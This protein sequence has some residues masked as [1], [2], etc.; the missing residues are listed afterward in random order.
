MKFRLS[1]L[2][3]H[4]LH[5]KT[6][7][8][9]KSTP[10]KDEGFIDRAIQL[11]PPPLPEPTSRTSLLCNI[12]FLIFISYSCIKRRYGS[13]KDSKEGGFESIYP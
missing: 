9:E 13:S 3:Y 12:I 10:I 1:C 5:S 6:A 4:L 2:L 8:A 11:A 7:S